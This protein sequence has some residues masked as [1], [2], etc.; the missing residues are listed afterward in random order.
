MANAL[1]DRIRALTLD[2]I[3]F[4]DDGAEA[5]VDGIVANALTLDDMAD[6]FIALAGGD[7]DQEDIANA[8]VDL[9]DIFDDAALTPDQSAKLDSV[10]DRLL[11][12]GSDDQKNAAKALFTATLGFGTAAKDANAYFDTLLSS[13]PG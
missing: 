2:K 11:K 4:V 5:V 9:A 6:S 10:V 3:D 12:S 7:A 8:L 13:Q 1:A